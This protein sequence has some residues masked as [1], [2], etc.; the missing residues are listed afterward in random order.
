MYQY[1]WD[2]DTRGLLLTNN[3][4]GYSKEPRPVFFEELDLLGFG[5]IW[6]YPHVA[7]PIMWAELN[8]YI[9]KGRIVARL[10]GGSLNNA[11]VITL[12][13]AP[14]P[15]GMPL[16]PVDVNT[17]IAKNE[18]IMESLVQESIQRIYNTYVQYK[19]RADV[20][21]V[22]FSGGKDSLVTL[23]LVQRALPH[24]D[25][26]VLFGD[27]GMEFPDT[28]KAIETVKA[29]CDNL[30]IRFET[31][32]SDVAAPDNWRTFGPP[33]TTM[34]WCCSVHKTSPQIRLLKG[35]LDKQDF[36]GFAYVGVRRDESS[37]RS[38]YDYISFG[39]KHRGQYSCNAILE[40][41]SAEV[42]LYLFAHQLLLNDAYR[43]GSRRVG[44]L[45]CPGATERAEYVCN[46]RYPD[47]AR[48][49]VE[50]IK[51]LYRNSFSSE[52]ALDRFVEAGGWKARKNGRDLPLSIGYSEERQSSG[53]IV[54]TVSD[55]KSNWRQWIK[56]IGVLINEES[57]FKVQF[58][59]E[60]RHFCLDPQTGEGDYIVRID[61]ETAKTEPEYVKHI[62]NVFRKAACCQ[63][64]GE[65]EADC[66]HGNL[67]FVNG[68]VRI[69][70]NCIHCMQCHK[71]SLGCL[72]YKS[73]AQPKGGIIMAG[74]KTSL[75]SYSHFAPRMDW[76]K[77]YL[78]YKDEFK[79]KHTLGSQMYNFFRAFL[80]DAELLD[81]NG[82]TSTARVVDRLGLSSNLAWGI[83]YVNVC[84]APQVNWYVNNVGY[85]EDYTNQYLSLLLE[86]YG[87]KG[88]PDI[89]KS[90][91]QLSMLPLGD[92]GFG[93]AYIEKRHVISIRRSKWDNP[94][95]LVILY[96]LYK[97]AEACGFRQ[98]TLDT[99]Y[100]TEV[101]R[102]GVSPVLMF[103]LERE[104]L[105]GTLNGLSVNYPDCISASFTLD[106]DSINLSADKTSADIL[107]L[108]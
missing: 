3:P 101:E 21:Y 97:F 104:Q 103:G 34:R 33:S 84:Y 53:D 64:C 30:G 56:T 93:K 72:V 60:L 96:A 12:V 76:M 75:N 91:S 67:H 17:M 36:T 14:E 108:M 22:A 88:I 70:D 29:Y 87:A 24:S 69:D 38:R 26:L 37:S 89:I 92:I 16:E 25:F 7:E 41:S 78:E 46:A 86:E 5:N 23:D 31:A 90:L 71:A 100:D 52:A 106:L 83:I 47:E 2:P 54:L 82:F 39:E 63:A 107:E 49:F 43:K 57:P 1:I 48:V 9:Y 105:I 11:P 98:F 27:T 73:L 62:K 8:N 74:K 45:I 28:Y 10:K 32:K 19:G 40:W 18:S 61:S 55:P 51:E 4:S 77:Q 66:S 80:R 15:D 13:E 44:C 68:S 50:T 94:E 95:P 79:D 99:L 59:D 65:C 58:K 85:D 102:D 81:K 20:F 6:S 42:Y 35:L